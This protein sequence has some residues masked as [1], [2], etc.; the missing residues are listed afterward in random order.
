MFF[1]SKVLNSFLESKKFTK[2]NFKLSNSVR[3]KL[4]KWF[5]V[6]VLNLFW[7]S[8]IN[9]W[10]KVKL[11]SE[12]HNVKTWQKRDDAGLTFRGRFG[13]R[14]LILYTLSS[15]FSRSMFKNEVSFPVAVAHCES[16]F[17]FWLWL[18][19]HGEF[20][21]DVLWASGQQLSQSHW[22]VYKQRVAR[23]RKGGFSYVNGC[24]LWGFN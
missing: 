9:S 7:H 22:N 2:I 4:Q 23:L 16:R 14:Q 18:S 21:T 1:R 11:F 19:A 13:V 20:Y 17:A 10:N 5:T 3:W 15:T 6:Y 24:S 8:I 12:E